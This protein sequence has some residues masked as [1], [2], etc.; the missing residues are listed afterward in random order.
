MAWISSCSASTH[1]KLTSTGE[2]GDCCDWWCPCG[3][4]TPEWVPLQGAA[5]EHLLPLWCQQQTKMGVTPCP[6]QPQ[7]PAASRVR[8]GRSGS[9]GLCQGAGQKGARGQPHP[10]A[11]GTALETGWALRVGPAQWGA[12]P[13]RTGGSWRSAFLWCCWGLTV[14]GG[15]CGGLAPRQGG[16]ALRKT[17]PGCQPPTLLL[18]IRDMVQSLGHLWLPQGRSQKEEEGQINIYICNGILKYFKN[19]LLNYY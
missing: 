16:A 9:Q 13:G 4:G 8:L 3:G 6:G 10:R 17:S 12:W 19:Y 1:F 14:P 5:G 11:L 15:C 18:L 2:V 7:G